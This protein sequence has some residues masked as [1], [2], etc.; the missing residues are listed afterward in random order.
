V[1]ISCD[2]CRMEGKGDRKKGRDG[3]EIRRN[4]MVTRN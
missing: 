3:M 1:I 2:F 4:C